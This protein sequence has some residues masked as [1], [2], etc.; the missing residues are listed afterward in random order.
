MVRTATQG[1]TLS[2]KFRLKPPHIA[3]PV[4]AKTCKNKNAEE[5]TVN[6]TM[7]IT[8]TNI[9]SPEPVNPKWGTAPICG[10]AVDQAS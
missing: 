8:T 3:E 4:A 1:P 6:T 10:R 5:Q 7:K 2:E 9:N